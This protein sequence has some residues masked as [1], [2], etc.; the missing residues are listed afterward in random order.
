MRKIL[1]ISL[2]VPILL[3]ACSS[4]FKEQG[5]Y[6]ERDG[7]KTLLTDPL[8]G[9]GSALQNLEANL[10]LIENADY[11]LFLHIKD[12]RQKNLFFYETEIWGL[13]E[14]LP[15]YLDNP[16]ETVYMPFVEK[17][18]SD[19]YQIDINQLPFRGLL[20]MVYY[21]TPGKVKRGAISF[22]DFDD[23]VSTGLSG[24]NTSKQKL[25]FAQDVEFN[26][27]HKTELA[28]MAA[29]YIKKLP[30]LK[31]KELFY[32]AKD[33]ERSRDFKLREFIKDFPESKYRSRAEALLNSSQQGKQRYSKERNT[34]D[35]N[36]DAYYT[37]KLL[38]ELVRNYVASVN[39]QNFS[40]AKEM[41]T[42]REHNNIDRYQRMAKILQSK[43][44][45]G[46]NYGKTRSTLTTPQGTPPTSFQ[47]VNGTWKI[48]A[49]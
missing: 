14:K 38:I 36:S 44:Y 10:V 9:T 2:F 7:V 26:Y 22:D 37:E 30:E 16:S 21:E 49:Y 3:L 25:K 5:F 43:S 46:I 47:F 32:A 19:V 13:N 1:I 12:F 29:A 41:A 11:K 35:S 28:E 23:L 42:G 31:E 45:T 15:E 6:L 4:D 20:G 17:V 40:A 34:A 27:L 48:S 33:S 18:Q 39:T 24:G 8:A